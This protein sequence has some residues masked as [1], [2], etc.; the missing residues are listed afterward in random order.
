M[1]KTQ[2]EKPDASPALPTDSG[3]K[4]PDVLASH[5]APASVE[6]VKEAVEKDLPVVD[7]PK[8][9]GSEGEPLRAAEMVNEEQGES[10]GEAISE[11]PAATGRSGRF[12][13]LATSVALAAAFGSFVGSMSASGFAHLWSLSAGRSN[14]A[15][16]SAPQTRKAELAELSALKANLDGA[17]RGANGQL[18]KIAERLDRVE[19]ALIDPTKIAHIADAVD[20]LE[21]RSAASPETT[22]SITPSP[23]R[24]AATEAKPSDRIVRDWMV[25]DVR[26]GRALVDTPRGAVFEVT[27]GSI[28]PGLGRVEAIRRQDGQWIVVTEHGVI[29][30]EP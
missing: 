6:P 3:G 2:E 14:I 20:K 24:Q 7:A 1:A 5:A 8:L 10:A 21:K 22:G 15:A 27:A 4:T 19:H 17:T 13:L 12:A 23:P 30:S 16:A 11:P 26:G 18:A 28:L 29:T 25:Q 9:D